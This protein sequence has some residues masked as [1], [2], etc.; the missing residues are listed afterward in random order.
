LHGEFQQRHRDALKIILALA[1]VRQSSCASA[2]PIPMK[3]KLS[4]VLLGLCAAI[5]LSLWQRAKVSPTQSSVTD[6]VRESNAAVHS[7][8][9]GLAA[10]LTQMDSAATDRFIER[11]AVDMMV[12]QAETNSWRRDEKLQMFL[13][14]ITF[15]DIP[16]ALQ[17]VQR[18]EQ[19]RVLQDLQVL[20]V[21]K[22][23]AT[24]PRATA[25]W[26]EQM[27]VGLTRSA[28]LAGV[29]VV[30]ANQDLPAAA[31][32]ALELSEG[33]DRENGL[34]HVAFEA[35]RTQPIFALELAANLAPNDAREE[36]VRHA[37]RQWAAQD[38]AKA[39]TWASE[40]TNPT[41]REKIVAHIAA[42]WGESDPGS[43]A[44][45]ALQSLSGGTLQEDA[46]V[47]IAQ[48]WAQKEPQR[49]AAW[50]F[51]FPE[52]FQPTALENVIKIWASSD[53]RNATKWVENLPSGLLRETALSVLALK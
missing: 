41:L 49:A 48:H 16:T 25:T 31:N 51:D 53:V 1:A 47:G 36:L 23:A 39:A 7:T 30:W 26:A 3:R 29:G 17:F 33:E 20:L 45:L 4:V 27:P 37:A 28:S 38:P 35:A 8:E 32:W 15:N 21:R 50:V 46:L 6:V 19:T 44:A 12:L 10:R 14:S 18:Q 24:D 13:D 5:G 11:L 22:G 42:T 2:K 52:S 9:K 34:G 40:L 43:A